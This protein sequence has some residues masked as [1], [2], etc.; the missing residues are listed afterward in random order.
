MP[1]ELI[2]PLSA[3][4]VYLIWASRRRYPPDREAT[5]LAKAL[6]RILQKAD[7]YDNPA[8]LAGRADRA[9]GLFL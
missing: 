4:A 1:M 8:I 5:D 6:P 2:I 9:K 7:H 3:L